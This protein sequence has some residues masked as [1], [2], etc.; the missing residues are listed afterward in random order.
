VAT[1]R[2]SDDL[3]ARLKHEADQRRPPVSVTALVAEACEQ[4]L[5]GP[6]P[7]P[8]TAPEPARAPEPAAARSSLSRARRTTGRSSNRQPGA[9]P[10]SHPIGRR[11]SGTCLVCGAKVS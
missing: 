5:A 9:T 8:P 10:C 6:P 7:A 2:L 4:L 11:I 3:N 1:V